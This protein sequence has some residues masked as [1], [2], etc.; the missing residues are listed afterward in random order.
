M[1]PLGIAVE[2]RLRGREGFLEAQAVRV[3]PDLERWR[4]LLLRQGVG[5]AGC[6]SSAVI[7]RPQRGIEAET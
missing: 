4:A 6:G 7:G 1:F 5:K 3:T 2:K